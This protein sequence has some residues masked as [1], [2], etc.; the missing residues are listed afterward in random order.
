MRQYIHHVQTWLERVKPFV[1][2]EALE[3]LKMELERGDVERRFVKAKD[4]V[5]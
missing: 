2:E 5:M 3:R 1:D 4:R